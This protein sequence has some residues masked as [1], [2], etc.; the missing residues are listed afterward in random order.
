MAR[1]N[2]LFCDVDSF[3]LQ[4]AQRRAMQAELASMDGNRLLNT[5]G[6]D[7]VA[8]FVGKFGIEF[9]NCWKIR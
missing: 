7:L 3:R 8:Y 1:G 5:N 6:D 2:H 4:D 9:L